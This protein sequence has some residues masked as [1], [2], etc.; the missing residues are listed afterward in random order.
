MVGHGY[1]G[2]C[3][4]RELAEEGKKVAL[5]EVQR[6]ESYMAAGNESCSINSELMDSVNC[7][8]V[9]PVES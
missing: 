1:A 2:T 5:V 9:D 7:P 3:A 8:H 4:C 6:Q